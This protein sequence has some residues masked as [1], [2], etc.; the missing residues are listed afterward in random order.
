MDGHLTKIR[1][2][3]GSMTTYSPHD[4][5]NIVGVCKYRRDGNRKYN[6]SLTK[7]GDKYL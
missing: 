5:T 7:S 2:G 3:S 6:A 4:C 1:H